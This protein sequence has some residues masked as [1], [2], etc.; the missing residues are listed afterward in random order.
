MNTLDVTQLVEDIKQAATAVVNQDVATLSGF[1]ERQV[2]AL[3]KQAAMIAKGIA[4]GEIDAELQSFFLEGLE[5]MA[6][7]FAN[8]LSGLVM[9]TIEKVWNAVVA[10]LWRAIESATGIVLATVPS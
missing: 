7:N 3:A 4:E 5:D 9:V 1:S 6:L 8:T 2:T 10:I